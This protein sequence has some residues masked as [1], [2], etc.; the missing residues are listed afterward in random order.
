MI[1]V[2]TA[3]GF[4]LLV[5]WLSRRQI[6]ISWWKWIPTVLGF[7]Y[8]VFVL[9]MVAGFLAEGASRAALVMGIITGFI[10]IVWGVLLGRFVF[11]GNESEGSVGS[12]SKEHSNV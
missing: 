4:F 8:A 6:R 2:I 3:T 10:G 9:E 11:H 7:L 5:N 1:G 12:I